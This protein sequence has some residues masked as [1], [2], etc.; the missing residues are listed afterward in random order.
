MDSPGSDDEKLQQEREAAL[1]KK[2]KILI[3]MLSLVLMILLLPLASNHGLPLLR[4]MGISMLQRLWDAMRFIAMTAAISIGIISTSNSNKHNKNSDSSLHYRSSSSSFR[5]QSKVP[6]ASTSREASNPNTAKHSPESSDRSGSNFSPHASHM[7][8]GE[9][10]DDDGKWKGTPTD[11]TQKLKGKGVMEDLASSDYDSTD[12]IWESVQSQSIESFEGT[13]YEG[14]N[15]RPIKLSMV[16][17]RRQ[18]SAGDAWFLASTIDEEVEEDSTASR[19]FGSPTS[20]FRDVGGES[21]ITRA[22]SQKTSLA[23]HGKERSNKE[24]KIPDRSGLMNVYN[25]MTDDNYAEL[26]MRKTAVSRLSEEYHDEGG[27]D[28]RRSSSVDRRRP[29]YVYDQKNSD[30]PGLKQILMEMSKERTG[31]S[32]MSDGDQAKQRIIERPSRSH[33]QISSSPS[34]V[35]STSSVKQSMKANVQHHQASILSTVKLPSDSPADEKHADSKMMGINH[36]QR[37]AT[38]MGSSGSLQREAGDGGKVGSNQS[39]QASTSSEIGHKQANAKPAFDYNMQP[40]EADHSQKRSM[41]KQV[42]AIKMSSTQQSREGDSKDMVAGSGS[43]GEQDDGKMGSSQALNSEDLDQLLQ[44]QNAVSSKLAFKG[45]NM[46]RYHGGTGEGLLK[47][48]V[49]S[50]SRLRKQSSQHSRSALNLEQ[51]GQA[52]QIKLQTRPPV[53][54]SERRRKSISYDFGDGFNP[55]WL[56]ELEPPPPPGLLGSSTIEDEQSNTSVR[57][58][59]SSS[60]VQSLVPWRSS[61]PIDISAYPR[62]ASPLEALSSGATGPSPGEVN[63]RADEFISNFTTRLIRQRQESLER[64]NRN[65]G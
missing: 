29:V 8:A 64:H 6:I 25:S 43:P 18:W 58:A 44:M 30:Q 36:K 31:K 59:D 55:D 19:V 21:S 48:N 7:P 39:K 33:V 3:I 37:E 28:H 60:L 63:R 27:K 53:G 34:A 1:S 47:N 24:K 17:S 51:L 65:F 62:A 52:D 10:E 40:K 35:A 54:S 50:T 11:N 9:G 56:Q 42:D 15:Y 2:M 57:G 13:D 61:A 32:K 12:S 23:S 20:R 16:N 46:Q 45:A 38:N 49:S 22:D 5:R 14:V 41:Q 4:P 26:R